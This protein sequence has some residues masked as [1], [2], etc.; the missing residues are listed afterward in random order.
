VTLTDVSGLRGL[1][2][3]SMIAWP[4]GQCDTTSSVRWL[5][6]LCACIDLRHPAAAVDFSRLRTGGDLTIDHCAWLA[7]QQGFAGRCIFDGGHFQWL[8]TIDFQPKS[9]CDDVGSLCW[10]GGVLVETGRDVAYVEHWHRDVSAPTLPAAAVT[11]REANENTAAALL[12]V[13]AVF[14]FARDR[15]VLPAAGRT[16]AECVAGAPSLKAAQQLVD[17]EIS[18]GAVQG[19]RFQITASSLPFRIGDALDPQFARQ[20][21]TTLDRAADG[22]PLT[23][24]WEITAGE[25]ELGALGALGA[26]DA[27]GA[28]GSCGG[29]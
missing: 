24:R 19:A 20:R 5:Q 6:G 4:D 22:A 21:L 29:H 17:C 11:L 13:G 7:Q 16:L 28:A 15:A 23:R 2:R 27:R 10:Q 9:P 25:G 8:R 26:G 12:R 1:W 18:F 14:M 3:R